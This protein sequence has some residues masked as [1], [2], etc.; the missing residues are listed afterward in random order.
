MG[1]GLESEEFF[2]EGGDVDGKWPSWRRALR[3]GFWEEG[4]VGV[5]GEG[6]I[7]EREVVL[8]LLAADVFLLRLLLR[9]LIDWRSGCGRELAMRRWEA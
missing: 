2:A 4:V 1:A 8:L 7:V 5:G 3:K 9:A 6:F